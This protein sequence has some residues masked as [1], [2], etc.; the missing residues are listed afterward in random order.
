MNIERI[1]SL[2]VLLCLGL[3][4]QTSADSTISNCDET[5]LRTAISAGGTV[6]ITC[7]GVI[8][9]SETIAITNEVIITAEGHEV[10]LSGRGRVRVLEALPGSR[11]SLVN[12][13]ISEGRSTNGAGI[14]NSGELDLRNCTF[15]MN[16]A[17]GRPGLPQ[18]SGISASGGAVY[19]GGSLVASNCLFL[20][21]QVT[22]GGG[23]AGLVAGR[24]GHGSGGALYNSGP[25]IILNCTFSGNQAL[26]G[27]GGSGDMTDEFGDGGNGGLGGNAAG[28]A[29]QNW[30]NLQIS[31]TTFDLNA[32]LGGRGG[33]GGP[34]LYAGF[35][36][37]GG[38]GVGGAISLA[39]GALN[40]TNC[41]FYQNSA[42][43]GNGGN[44]GSGFAGGGYGGDGGDGRA[45]FGGGVYSSTGNSILI[46]CTLAEN[47][48]QG[49]RGGTGGTSGGGAAG[50]NGSD[51]LSFGG[52]IGRLGGAIR[53][54]QSIISR[55]LS[56]ANVTGIIT[57][58]GY[59][60]SSDSSVLFTAPGSVTNTDPK[61][62]ALS[63]NGGA[64][65]T[66]ALLAGSP[67]IDA[68]TNVVCLAT[69]QRG[70]ARPQ[71]G[72]CDIGAF[73]GGLQLPIVTSAFRPTAIDPNEPSI[74]DV[75]VQNPNSSE[76]TDVI[77]SN[78]LPA[79]LVLAPSNAP[80]TTCSGSVLIHTNAIIFR[81]ETIPGEGSCTF[82]VAVTSLI[83][84]FHT[85]RL[86][87]LS[88]SQTGTRAISSEAVLHI[89][90]APHVQTLEASSITTTSALL[91]AVANPRGSS[92]TVYFEVGETTSY[93]NRT[94]S[95]TIGDGSTP[96]VV[97]NL[98]SNLE[99]GRVYHY[100]AVAENALGRTFGEDRTFFV[101]SPALY[102]L[103]FDGT[104]DFVA[105]PDIRSSFSNET[106]T[107]ELWFRP[108]AAGVIIDER[109]Q[110]PPSGGWQ[111][112]L[113]EILS[114][115][116]VRARVNGVPTITLGHADFG[117]WHH[118]ALRYESANLT[119]SGILDDEA[120]RSSSGDRAAPWESGHQFYLAFGL[121]DSAHM[122]SGA[123]FSGEMDEIRIWNTVRR[124]VEIRENRFARLAGNESG[125][126]SYWRC[127][128]GDGVFANDAASRYTAALFN[129]VTWVPSMAPLQT[130]LPPFAS[131]RPA[132]DVSTNAATLTGVVSP[133]GVDT[134]VFFEYGP[135]LN[136][137]N[138]T[139]VRV[140]AGNVGE[141]S[142][143]ERLA[144]LLS[145]GEYNYRIV[146]RNARG[147][148]VG[149]N[150]LVRV[151]APALYAVR[152]D[153]ANDF[154]TT[155]N[156]NGV[157]PSETIT[158]ELWFKPLAAGVLID[159]RGQAPPGGGWQVT[160][161]E[162]LNNGNVL[163]RVN[164]LSPI[165]IGTCTF[166]EWHHVALRYDKAALTLS[167]FLNGVRS[168]ATVS[169]DRAAPAESGFPFYLAFGLSDNI[170][171]GSGAFFRGEMDEIRVWNVART[172]IEITA[173]FARR[174][175]LPSPGLVAYWP[176]DGSDEGLAKDITT[177]RLD[178]TFVGG[179]VL[180]PSG[181]P[182]SFPQIRVLPAS[183][184]TTNSAII[185]GTL[186][187]NGN[188]A[189]YYF[190][191]GRTTNYGNITPPIAVT[192]N[193]ST[194]RPVS[195]LL[196]NLLEATPY[197][198]RLVASNQ[199]GVNFSSD[200]L[201]ST[202]GEASGQA[203]RLDGTNAFV[204][205]SDLRRFFASESITIE[206]WFKPLSHG[207]LIDER[208][209]LPPAGGWQVTFAEVLPTGDVVIRVH[210]GI[211]PI[212]IGRVTF[213]EWQH[214]VLRYDKTMLTLHGFL[215]GVQ[216]TAATGD[217]AAPW[218]FGGGQFFGFGLAG[219]TH[220]GSGAYFKGEL[221]EIRIWNL[222]RATA[223]ILTFMNRRLSGRELGLVAYW[224]CDEGSGQN[225]QD[226]S[227]NGNTALF[228]GGIS[229]VVSSAPLTFLFAATENAFNI[230]PT[231]ATLHGSI[232]P[233]G[234]A[235]KT[236]FEWGP[237]T[238]LGNRTAELQ[239]AP[240]EPITNVAQSIRA[241]QPAS[242]YYFRIV[243]ERAGATNYGAILAFDTAGDASGLAV[244][245]DGQND[246]IYSPN[247]RSHVTNETFTVE[248]WFKPYGPGVIIDERGQA[249]PGPAGQLS[250]LEVLANGEVRGRVSN[251]PPFTLG[252]IAFNAWHHVAL[253][254]D[255]Q[256]Q[257]L[258]G[259]LNGILASGPSG[260]RNAPWEAGHQW[261]LGFGLSD[262][263]NMGSGAYLWA[264]ID[265]VRIWNS[266]RTDA[267]ITSNRFEPLAGTEPNLIA[268]WRMDESMPATLLSDASGRAN[269]GSL[270]NGLMRVPST[271]PLTSFIPITMQ[272]NGTAVIKFRTSSTA[273][274]VVQ[275]SNDLISWQPAVTNYPNRAGI[276][277]FEDSDARSVPHRFFRI[278][279]AQ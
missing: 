80:I 153:G 115:G 257:L 265:E 133:R 134:E 251:L 11:V 122:G 207:V 203:L 123:F 27:Q 44:G 92:T 35:G 191:W 151:P 236:Y 231:S 200:M 253:R 127:D 7:D 237:T 32:A 51:G 226:S 34:G 228:N 230:N 278:V 90:G 254:Y 139:P 82:S 180:V 2:A 3:V 102:A 9:L 182:M 41:T 276:I 116:E 194:T 105:T 261:Y 201:F 64:T 61:L 129:G 55:S 108:T 22:G 269:H 198:F 83:P 111:I 62:G 272:P 233:N 193:L 81:S 210:N 15:T 160:W 79:G 149:E 77:I 5:A 95:R 54:E 242:T 1:V 117:R 232:I 223:D 147:T 84:G 14:F 106:L 37:H 222:P 259:F 19:S 112:T 58:G 93:G 142:V 30:G 241:L 186:N 158:V 196:V 48:A 250:L 23:G 224:R 10:T 183:G 47:R 216:S 227:T 99:S 65:R 60:I 68:I 59:N 18:S 109:G 168:P 159:E 50:P 248:L 42:V 171:L 247:L 199:H 78:A 161:L 38:S 88:S 94:S 243:A 33:D 156:L 264:E 260:D 166:G 240:S 66:M 271:A 150:Q 98:A 184:V 169:G 235:I 135:T 130:T 24:A 141:A 172:D 155:P 214:L 154:I 25:G 258:S 176:F 244:S 268:Y 110:T 185:H 174:L 52:N 170:N 136:Y 28:G 45:G 120:T 220:M 173:N 187:P 138:T 46:G 279:P 53:L 67:A 246:F 137:G 114:S 157:F 20:N 144:N 234:L 267:E 204:A 97:T 277:S 56:G 217:R 8:E 219:P 121:A 208:G 177:N 238:N 211:G 188:A 17:L 119:L 152:L 209:Q 103:R 74:L 100:R 266:A 215:N 145:G 197:H 57:D 167:G 71:G 31:G 101:L 89:R 63:D 13:H 225:I 221:D 148:Y 72:G 16:M 128:E 143:T 70:V 175:T 162:V 75:T 125:L 146:A 202:A 124:D 181:V 85:N 262:T 205:T 163:G 76:L 43:G 96:I 164:N 206:L 12:L 245:L 131:T 218:E 212:N 104:N 87:Q 4:N 49:G 29:I 252:R 118:V 40:V 189:F 239:I 270:I 273:P 275:Q 73:E 249:P 195:L 274:Y 263:A 140:I 165:N 113:L 132:L 21:N 126:V 69:D 26:G 256:S 6:T 192:N 179:P 36:D 107:V 39:A 86:L 91:R 178:G 229:W 255:R 213:G 190:E